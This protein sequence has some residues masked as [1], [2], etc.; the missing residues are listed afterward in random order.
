MLIMYNYLNSRLKCCA[1]F[2]RKGSILADIGTDHALLPIYLVKNN[3]ISSCIACDI[4]PNPL[5]RAKN[6]IQRHSLSNFITTRLS[7][8]LKNVYEDEV[9]D[10]V[11]AGMG[12]RLIAKIISECTWNS[13]SDK[14][15]ILQ[16]MYLDY[17]LRKFLVENKYKIVNERL[18]KSK[19]KVYSVMKVEYVGQHYSVDK[20][21]FYVGEIHFDNS[22][23]TN[24][25]LKT[26]LN[27]LSNRLSGAKNSENSLQKSELKYVVEYLRAILK[28]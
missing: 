13:K 19:K 20:L 25:Y 14:N 7:D 15:F 16:P 22:I 11:I 28:N 6:N 8:G 1:D 3:I 5:E 27:D 23:T 2:V 24:L 21:Y 10:V 26:L 9:N 18:V 17:L 4:N 12:G